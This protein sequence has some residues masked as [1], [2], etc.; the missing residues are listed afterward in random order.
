MVERRGALQR[1]PLART[2][3]LALIGLTLVLAGIAAL[4]IGN[5][6]DARQR[7]ENE[8][9]RTYELEAASARLLAAGVIEE[10]ALA[11]FGRGS[12]E[13]RREAAAAFEREALRSLSLAGEDTESRRLVR[14]RIRAQRRTR[15][16]ARRGSARGLGG[17]ILG[18]R[19]AGADLGARQAA[20]RVEAR[21]R[22]QDDSRSALITAGVAG[23][24]GV[25]GAL[26]VIG[27]LIGT[28]RRPLE[29]LVGATR[30]LAEGD[31]EERV[32]PGGPEE[33]TGLGE[34]FNTMAGRLDSAQHRIEDERR[35]LAVTIESLGDALVVCDADGVVTAVNPRAEQIVPQLSPG[36]RA[37]A[38]GSP[39]PTLEEALEGE[40]LREEGERTL[41]ITAS[42]LGADGGEGTVW[43]IR[44]VSER[45]A[46]DRMK[47]DFVATASHELR[48][49]LTSIKGFVELLARSGDLGAREREFVEVILQSTDR[50]VELVNDLLDVARLEAG[51]MEVH[52]RLFDLGEVVREVADLMAPR[53]EEKEQRLD[54]Y[55]PPG[56]PRALADPGRVRQI[57]TN[58]LSNAHQYTGEG[59]HL[60][61]SLREDDG[62]LAVAFSDTGRGMTREE[63][64]Q[65][66]DRFV[67][68]EDGSGG[69]G[70]GLAIVRSLV[71]LQGGSIDVETEPGAGSTFTVQLPAEP[72]AGSGPGPRSA[73]RGKRVLVVDDEPE[74]AALIAEQL[75]GFEVETEVAH[76][77]E[78]ALER[79]RAG[80][81]DAMTLDL[82]MPGQS[83]L[84]VLRLLREDPELHRTPVV[85]V[86]I[87]SGTE[88]LLGEWKVGKPVDA[89]ELADVLGSAVMAGRTR[90]LV[91]GRSALRE[92]LE[93]ALV[94]LGLDHEWV[95]SGTA[96]A[97]VC[98]R[99][100]FEVALVDAGIREPDEVVREL[101]LR[102]RRSGRAVVLFSTGDD[103]PGVANLGA[104][105]VPLDEA[106]GAVLRALGEGAPEA[107]GTVDTGAA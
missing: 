86:S 30:R 15:R 33:L 99:R 41:S 47:S 55:V 11:R 104:S 73:I 44:D 85:V 84:D 59:G 7:Y 88:A 28:I 40:V 90:V 105:T 107:S 101:D 31:L 3:R 63:L 21:D 17:A 42:R 54:V 81:F 43:T 77:G 79:L 72:A 97:Q 8:L 94:R 92:R 61:V 45:A 14:V 37:E 64:D 4:A 106:A 46:L 103:A 16:A 102:G 50:L 83:G 95:T 58:L 49:P 75:A 48:S 26:L 91:V 68:R 51:K 12:G 89:D 13:L 39:L 96:A 35:K 34:A 65:I 74:I 82:L 66:F 1:L 98:G 69:T 10:S 56:L 38:D 9:A 24:L 19:Q 2:M 36:V 93:P 23:A 5:L 25:L 78:E 53:I 76:S 60:R 70:L 71:D 80:H 29:D 22:A 32:E 18:A 20:R 100:R 87:L 67:R 6:Y 57:V 62:R 27:G 52:P